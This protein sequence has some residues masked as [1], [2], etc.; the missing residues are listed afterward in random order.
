[1]LSMNDG[2]TGPLNSGRS[3]H[4]Q[5]WPETAAVVVAVVVLLALLL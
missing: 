3:R 5:A 2:R 1:M 4:A